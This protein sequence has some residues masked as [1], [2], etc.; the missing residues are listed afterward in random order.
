MK[1]LMVF[2]LTVNAALMTI[3]IMQ[4]LTLCLIKA[5]LWLTELIRLVA[6]MLQ[7]GDK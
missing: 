3:L 7:G 6:M 5:N 4:V 2:M 1:W